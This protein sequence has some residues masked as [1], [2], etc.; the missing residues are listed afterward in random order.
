MLLAMTT[1]PAEPLGDS[2]QLRF[3]QPVKEWEGV[4]RQEAATPV[5]KPAYPTNSLKQ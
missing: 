1:T 2:L 3:S 5:L 4:V